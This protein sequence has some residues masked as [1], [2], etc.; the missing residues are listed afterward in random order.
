MPDVKTQA[1]PLGLF[2]TILHGLSVLMTAVALAAVAEGGAMLFVMSYVPAGMSASAVLVLA[3]AVVSL[4][5]TAWLVV[6]M[7]H[8]EG[9]SPKAARVAGELMMLLSVLVAGAV[10]ALAMFT[11]TGLS[12][13][14]L[15]CS[16]GAILAA[17]VWQA[18]LVIRSTILRRRVRS[19]APSSE[20]PPSEP[21]SPQ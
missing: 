14:L 5:I 16:A 20:A 15:A 13:P 18:G 9:L 10:A 4:T 11:E 12:G 2:S 1:V 6:T 17:A 19:E 3:S 8:Q 7:V 21:T